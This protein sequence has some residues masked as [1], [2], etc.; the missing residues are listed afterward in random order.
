MFDSD[1]FWCDNFISQWIFKDPILVDA[2]FMRKSISTNNGLV[3]RN[4]N[5]R[6]TRNHFRSIDCFAKYNIRASLV[7]V[8]TYIESNSNFLK[9]CITC[10]FSNAIDSSFNT[11]CPRFNSCQGISC[12]HS[13]IIVAMGTE[14]DF[15]S[16]F[17][18]G[19]KILENV[20]IF[21][22][23]CEANRIRNIDISSTSIYCRLNNL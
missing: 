11:T 23:G 7:I 20:T 13:K 18:I 3:F 17:D 8:F 5:A 4:W 19:N 12:C 9:T 14:D 16:R 1:Q 6:K 15:M 10:T 22:W 21:T 2:R